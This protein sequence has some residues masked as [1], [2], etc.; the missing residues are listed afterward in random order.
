VEEYQGVRRSLWD[1]V[2]GQ[3][4]NTAQ[5]ERIG[6]AMKQRWD[7]ER[8]NGKEESRDE[9][10]RSES[11]PSKSQEEGTPSSTSY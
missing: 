8:E 6:T 10:K 11:S 4:R 3:K 1:L 7:L 2:E 9:E 5:L